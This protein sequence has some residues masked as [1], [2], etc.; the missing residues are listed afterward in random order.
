[1]N[2]ASFERM[3]HGDVTGLRELAL[4]FFDEIRTQIPVWADLGAKG[5]F[6]VL[7]EELHRCK[8]GASIFGLDRMLALI[9]AYESAPI[10]EERGFDAAEFEAE[11]AAAE[12]AVRA[13]QA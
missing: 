11:F 10:L 4:E 13:L 2:T 1:M 6:T 3:A 12:E 7:I 5:N 9:H 8:G